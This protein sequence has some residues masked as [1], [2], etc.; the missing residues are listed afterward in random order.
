MR[1]GVRGLLV[2]AMCAAVGIVARRPRGRR[3]RR[4]AVPARHPALRGDALRR[5]ARGVPTRR[6][7]RR[8]GAAAAG[9]HRRREDG[10]AG[11]RVRRGAARSGVA[12]RRLAASNPEAHGHAR[13]RAVVGGPVRRIGARVQ[14]GAG[15]RPRDVARPPRA[16]QGAGV[17]LEARGGAGR[18]AGG[19]AHRAPRRRAASHRRHASSSACTATTRPR[20]PTPTTSTC[21]PTRTAATRRCGRRRRSASCRRSR[22]ARPTPSTPTP[23]AGCTP[24]TSG[25]CRTRSSS[26]AQ[27]N[28]GRWADFVL[29]TGSEQ[30]TISRQVAQSGGVAPITYTLSAGVGEVGLRGL[31]LARL[32]TFEVGTLKVHDVPVLIKN[33]ALRGIPQPRDGELLADGARAVDDHRLRDPQADHRRVAARGA[34]RHPAADADAPAGD[35]ARADQRPSARPTSSSTP[36]AR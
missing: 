13:R 31:Q 2:V 23:P 10:A 25:W 33:P 22:T 12:A 19:A 20:R 4:A 36:A 9:A 6:R 35:G 21:C 3:R 17:A 11:R 27:V 1:M 29:D 15:R 32:N 24:S 28:G 30:T 14:R 16:G 5:S 26:R 7:H 34:G 18:G 8:S